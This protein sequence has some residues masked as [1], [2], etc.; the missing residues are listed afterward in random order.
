MQKEILFRAD[1]NSAIGLGHLYRLFSLVE[2]LKE[3]FTF[4]FLTS[5]SSAINVIPESYQKKTIPN[6]ITINE[7][8]NWISKEFDSNRY[9]LIADGYQFNSSYQ[10]K[11]KEHGFKLIYIDDLA[12]E[13]LFA[14][15]VINHSPGISKEDF[16]CESYTKF[17][18]GTNYALL[19][20][21]FLELSTKENTLQQLDTAFVCFGGADPYDLTLKA[22]K[23]LLKIKQVKRIHIVLG[24]AYVHKEIYNLNTDIVKI[25]QN[26]SE[27][28]LSKI[29]I[30]SNFAIAP[31]STILYELCCVKM[32]ILSG[33]Y[34]DNQKNIYNS[35][36][37]KGVVYKGGNFSNYS[38]QKFEELIRKMLLST[39]NYV[40]KQ[41]ELFDGKS[42]EK[43]LELLS[44]FFISFR[45]AEEKDLNKTFEWS[46]DTLVRNNS[47]NSNKIKFEEHKKWFLN[48]IYDKNSIF[49]IATFNEK[50]AGVIRFD[51]KKDY[52]IISILV[53]KESRGKKLASALLRLS[54]NYYFKHNT[55]PIFA[56]IKKENIASLK[57]FEK[58]GYTF[59][60]E[61]ENDKT[62]RIIYTLKKNEFFK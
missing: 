40:S 5:E 42:K 29:M 4:T 28:K 50:E 60:K 9:L 7:E 24:G 39:N 33:F 11:I 38:T 59:H 46:N 1:G 43:Y 27:K 23:A 53:A 19:R 44:S 25:Y 61:E 54:A 37:E 16:S 47:F 30:D 3:H 35:L 62:H 20:P 14:D 34:V 51:L 55:L 2:M 57:S 41:K 36:A 21:T 13:H 17:A 15:I 56:Y 22:T 26:L 49:L 32:P 48:K 12:S 52:S 18:L 31:A 6:Q 8:S 45:R 10:Q 58:A